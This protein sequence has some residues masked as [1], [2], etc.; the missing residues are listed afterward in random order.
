VSVGHPSPWTFIRCLKDE[1]GNTESSVD[2]ANKGHQQGEEN[3]EIL[4][5]D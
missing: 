3:G 2:A 4:K 5:A 1:Q